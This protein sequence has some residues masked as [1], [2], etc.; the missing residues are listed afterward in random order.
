MKVLRLSEIDNYL[1]TSRHYIENAKRLLSG[2]GFCC[3]G[4]ISRLEANQENLERLAWI[5]S[6]QN[7][8]GFVP[9]IWVGLA[10]GSAIAFLGSYVYKHYTDSKMQSDYLEC[11][12]QKQAE[13][14][15]AGLTT[16]DA[17]ERAGALCSGSGVSTTSSI[18]KNIT[19]VVYGAIV[20]MALY[21]GSKF[22]SK[23]KR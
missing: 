11:L 23:V 9:L 17:L 14:V 2:M 21:F 8:M 16:A 20:V 19:L 7:Q 22:I 10:A 5:K 15:A 12:N 18:E 6:H 13:L 4:Q 1:A 3:S